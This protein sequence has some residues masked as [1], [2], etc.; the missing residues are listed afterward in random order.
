MDIMEL[1]AIGELVGGVAVIASLVFVG[2]QVRQNNRLVANS[3]AQAA[4]DETSNMFRTLSADPETT[5]FYLDGLSEDYSDPRDRIRFDMIVAQVF[6]GSEGLY[7][8]YEEGELSREMF[9]SYERTF[10]PIFRQPGGLAC[11]GRRHQEFTPR[12]IE[13][14]DRNVIPR[15]TEER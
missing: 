11:W 1:G 8:R 3:V 7:Q 9:E 15:S 12:F 6:R 5:H 4:R 10:A 14:I 2:I 13:Y